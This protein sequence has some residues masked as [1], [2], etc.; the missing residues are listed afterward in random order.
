LPALYPGTHLTR[1]QLAIFIVIAL[2]L[3]LGG[4]ALFAR[5]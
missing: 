3:L 5:K 2:S 4:G 1:K